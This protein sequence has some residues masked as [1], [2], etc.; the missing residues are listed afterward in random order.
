MKTTFLISLIA[1]ALC[2]RQPAEAG[3]G[4]FVHPGIDMSRTDLEYM[5]R[6]VLEQ[7]EPWATAYAN[8]KNSV[9]APAVD[10]TGPDLGLPRPE[11]RKEA[12]IRAAGY[13][14]VKDSVPENAAVKAVSHV[15]GGA[16]NNPDIGASA[17]LEAADAAYDC[18]LL[19]YV[20]EDKRY[21]EKARAVIADWSANLRS[22]DDNNAKL[23]VAL[24]GY[25]FCNA[26]EILRCSY[27][28]W[29]DRDTDNFT[30]MLMQVYYPMLRLYFSDANGEVA[31]SGEGIDYVM[32]VLQV[33]EGYGFDTAQ[34]IPVLAG[35]ELVSVVLEKK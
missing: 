12:D 29:S 3:S 11:T 31:F 14:A 33:P 7:A 32:H 34:E 16:Y 8:L 6:K 9:P 27:P 24:T 26:A 21:A 4:K 13:A 23:L 25:Q 1:L 5:K 2:I 10:M 22:L 19:W 20:S 30:R 35:Q 15:V 28:G 17:I 18:A